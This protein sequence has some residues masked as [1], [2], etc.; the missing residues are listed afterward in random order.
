MLMNILRWS[1]FCW[2]DITNDVT[3][4]GLHLI[5]TGNI[6]ELYANRSNHYSECP[7]AQGIKS[8][9]L[10]TCFGYPQTLVVVIFLLVVTSLIV[11]WAIYEDTPIYIHDTLWYF[12]YLE[13]I[14]PLFVGVLTFHF[15]SQ[16][17]QIVGCLGSRYIY[18]I[19]IDCI[20]EQVLAKLT[21]KKNGDLLQGNALYYC[22]HTGC[23]WS[24]GSFYSCFWGMRID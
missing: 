6:R 2:Y 4:G 17:F 13:P 11:L 5:Y 24:L 20:F 23:W 16:I 15:M 10:F 1:D 22:N 3:Y 21:L 9:L 8:G 18:S 14:W 7:P 19:P 12:I